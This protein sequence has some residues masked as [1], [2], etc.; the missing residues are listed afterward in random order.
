[1]SGLDVTGPRRA[2]LA[3]GI[4]GNYSSEAGDR[5]NHY[6]SP[7]STVSPGS[8]PHLSGNATAMSNSSELNFALHN[9]HQDVP[10]PPRSAGAALGMGDAEG[11]ASSTFFFESNTNNYPHSAP[12]TS[13]SSLEFADKFNYDYGMQYAPNADRYPE[14]AYDGDAQGSSNG[15]YQ[16]MDFAAP[17]ESFYDSHSAGETPFTYS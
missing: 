17:P 10:Y 8:S 15:Q 1:M 14:V 5:D 2:S 3:E 16:N 11:P 9:K 12:A 7:S 6:P 4:I 13:D